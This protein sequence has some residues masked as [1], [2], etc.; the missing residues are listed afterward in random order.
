MQGDGAPGGLDR[1]VRAAATRALDRRP[2]AL[3]GLARIEHRVGAEAL[4]QLAACGDEI[5]A[6]DARR[7]RHPRQLDQE[8]PDRAQAEDRDVVADLDAGVVHGDEGDHAE[9]DEQPAL[10]RDARRQR[11]QGIGGA[12]RHVEVDDGLLAVRD[13]RVDEV[14]GRQLVDVV[15]DLCHDAHELIAERRRIRRAGRVER[16]ERAQLAVEHLVGEARGAAVEVQLG[17]VA[18]P[19]ERCTDT[20]VAR[21]ERGR[22]V[23]LEAQVAGAFQDE[24]PSQL[25]LLTSGRRQPREV[26]VTAQAQASSD[27]PQSARLLLMLAKVRDFRPGAD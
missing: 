23:G 18:D 25:P 8:Q 20:H 11:D 19:A 9:A 14:A 7:A 12:A 24:R 15:P 27:A 13:A 17:P 6:G 4:R 21:S 3:A 16:E 1:H 2:D 22:V 5:D 10:P 26:F